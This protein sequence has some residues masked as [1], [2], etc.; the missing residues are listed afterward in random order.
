MHWFLVVWRQQG[1]SDFWKTPARTNT[2]EH[3]P[4]QS[5]CSFRLSETQGNLTPF[6]APEKAL[7]HVTL[8]N[9]VDSIRLHC[10]GG[11]S[12]TLSSLAAAPEID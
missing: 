1:D 3:I 2:T 9:L 6:P 10:F 5:I 4:E 7:Q 12:L 8:P 11:A